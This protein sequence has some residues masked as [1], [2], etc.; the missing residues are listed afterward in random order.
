[1][2]DTAEAKLPEIEHIKARKN[3]LDVLSDIYRYAGLGF[4]AIEPDLTITGLAM[5]H[6][7]LLSRP[8]ETA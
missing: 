3:G 4:D 2:T 8:K 5:M 7:R 1:M 6:R